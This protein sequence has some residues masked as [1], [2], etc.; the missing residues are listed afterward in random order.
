MSDLI[1]W[2]DAL[3]VGVKEIDE[4]HMTLI[5]LVNEMHQAI[6]EH[7]GTSVTGKI[8]K[9][10]ILYT[11]THF[12]TEEALMRVLEFENFPAHK[13]A[14]DELIAQV[15]EL[16]EKLMIG[17]ASL[18]F[19]LMHF[20]RHWLTHHILGEDKRFGAYVLDVARTPKRRR[21]F[22]SR[23]RMRQSLGH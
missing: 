22:F 5:V 9:E 17:K 13:A 8:L 15:S 2:S 14:H 10:L 3:S 18:S 6:T 12:Q 4:Q 16:H 23:M 1:V 11:K 20:L 19:E 7:K 21:S